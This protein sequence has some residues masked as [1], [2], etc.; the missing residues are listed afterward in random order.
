MYRPLHFHK[1]QTN[2]FKVL[3]DANLSTANSVRESSF[4]YDDSLADNLQAVDVNPFLNDI[5]KQVRARIFFPDLTQQLTNCTA[6]YRY[7][8]Q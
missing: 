3:P 2:G 5:K 4:P 7:R 6:D 8:C 1:T